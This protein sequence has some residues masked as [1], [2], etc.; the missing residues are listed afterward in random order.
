MSQK[1]GSNSAMDSSGD[2]SPVESQDQQTRFASI[3]QDDSGQETE[4]TGTVRRNRPPAISTAT[5]TGTDPP[6]EHLK[7]PFIKP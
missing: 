3:I 1:K 5:G 7:L 2:A 6:A 4:R